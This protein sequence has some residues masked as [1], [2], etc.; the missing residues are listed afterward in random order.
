MATNTGRILEDLLALEGAVSGDSNV[1]E[2]GIRSPSPSV[3]FIFGNTHLIPFGA[4]AILWGPAKG[5]KSLLSLSMVGQLHKDYPDAYAIRFNSELREKFQASD[6]LF[7]NFNIDKKRFIRYDVNKPEQIFDRIENDI[8]AAC[9]KGLK[10]KLIIIDSVSDILGRKL[11]NAKTVNQ[12]LM[13]DDAST[14]QTGL[15]RIRSVIRKYNITLLLIAQQRDVLDQLEQMRGKKVKMKGAN[16]LKHFAEYFVY[17]YPNEAA[18]GRT[19]ILKQKFEDENMKDVAGHGDTFAHKIKAMM[20]DSSLGLAR[21]VGE[22]TFDKYRGIINT[23]EEAFRLGCARGIFEQ[24]NNRTYILKGFDGD[25]DLKWGSKEDCLLGIKDNE[26]VH[27]EIIKRV[28]QADIEMS[29]KGTTDIA[30]NA[31]STEEVDAPVFETE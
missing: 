15:Q 13:G 16:Y 14:I 26:L 31:T 23:H 7:N 21:R 3:N 8:V 22:F 2:E 19:D 4:S 1:F 20:Q 5:G 25:K 18:E 10:I 30:F 29:K 24:P 28:R 11:S 9:E 6:L 17:V 27:N 12:H